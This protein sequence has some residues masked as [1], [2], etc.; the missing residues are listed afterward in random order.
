M[1]R[2]LNRQA[3]FQNC[4][5]SPLD[6]PLRLFDTKRNVGESGNG[7]ARQ[8]LAGRCFGK[9]VPRQHLWPIIGV[10]I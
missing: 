8:I 10:E 2:R 7:S 1:R 9:A 4:A 3:P 5:G 6:Y